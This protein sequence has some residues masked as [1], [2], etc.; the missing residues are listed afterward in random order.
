MTKEQIYF[1][2]GTLVVANLGTNITVIIAALKLASAFG[3]MKQ[4]VKTNK[5]NITKAYERIRAIEASRNLPP[6]N[7]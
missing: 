5:G 6:P 7:C 2:V 3:E 1:I 4:Q